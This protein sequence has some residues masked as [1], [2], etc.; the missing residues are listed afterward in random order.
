MT[1]THIA[2]RLAMELSITVLLLKFF[3]AGIL[4]T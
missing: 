1:L 2:E 3:A 4:N